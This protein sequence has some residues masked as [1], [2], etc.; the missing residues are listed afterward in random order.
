MRERESQRGNEIARAM[1]REKES[2]WQSGAEA[3]GVQDDTRRKTKSW[4][5][6]RTRRV[7][8]LGYFHCKRSRELSSMPF[9]FTIDALQI[10]LAAWKKFHA[11]EKF[12]VQENDATAREKVETEGRDVMWAC[13]GRRRGIERASLRLSPRGRSSPGERTFPREREVGKRR[14]TWRR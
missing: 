3:T 8:H 2:G 12:L 11:Q 7:V 5:R 1:E 9:K 4:E 6:D 13:G 14:K 10:S